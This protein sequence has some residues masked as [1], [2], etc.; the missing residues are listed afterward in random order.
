MAAVSLAMNV[1][2]ICKKCAQ[3][4]THSRIASLAKN[5]TTCAQ[6][7]IGKPAVELF[8]DMQGAQA[9]IDFASGVNGGFALQARPSV[10]PM[11]VLF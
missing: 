1:H 3:D 8:P 10:L 6:E 5:S 2:I 4:L 11:S 7:A 9:S